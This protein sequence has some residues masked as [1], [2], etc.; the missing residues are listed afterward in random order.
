MWAMVMGLIS[1]SLTVW[2]FFLTEQ[3]CMPILGYLC[4]DRY[5]SL[6]GNNS[7]FFLLAL[8]KNVYYRNLGC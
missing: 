8:R 4:S 6:S 2:G 7:L 5:S 1:V 3:L